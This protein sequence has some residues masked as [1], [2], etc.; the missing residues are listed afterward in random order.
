MK[1]QFQTM[2]MR[3]QVRNTDVP[4]NCNTAAFGRNAL[5]NTLHN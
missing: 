2:A 3:N 5:E 1:L 4:K